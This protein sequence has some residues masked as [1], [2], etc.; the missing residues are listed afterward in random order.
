MPLHRHVTS[1]GGRPFP[2]SIP[3]GHDARF[4][5]TLV[6]SVHRTSF[7]E[8]WPTERSPC[9]LSLSMSGYSG[10]LP[11]VVLSR[12]LW[13]IVAPPL[14]GVLWHAVDRYR[15]GRRSAG[16]LR[17]RSAVV[18]Q[19]VADVA[20]VALAAVAT[21]AHVAVLRRDP[22]RTG[23]L[24][25]YAARGVR[26]GHLDAPVA[27][28]FDSLSA[29]ACTLACAV[30]LAA[31]ALVAWRPPPGGGGR[32]LAWIEL[33]LSGAL[34]SF[35]ADGLVAL[36]L[37]WAVAAASIG[38][39]AGWSDPKAGVLAATRGAF[40]LAALLLGGSLLFWG[41]GGTWRGDDYVGDSRPAFVAVRT[42][43]LDEAARLDAAETGRASLTLTSMPGAAV[44]VDE[45]P[46]PAMTTP[47]VAAPLTA[48]PHTL[49][50]RP[51]VE[52]NDIR[53]TD[54][55]G[56][57][58]VPW[59]AVPV[60]PTLS[61]REV[62][63]LSLVGDRQRETALT[64][65]LHEG[66]APAGLDL[67]SSVLALWTAAAW[68]V[69]G[70]S[71]RATAPQAAIAAAYGVTAAMLGPFLLARVSFLL[72]TA[73][74]TRV[75]F[76]S[77][78][79][80]MLV[81][82]LEHGL[83]RRRTPAPFRWTPLLAAAPGALGWM[84]LGMSGDPAGTKWASRAVVCSGLVAAGALLIVARRGSRSA[85]PVTPEPATSLALA[86]LLFERAP[87]RMGMLLMSYE[88]WVINATGRAALG[89]VGALAWA[90]ALT[91]RDVVVGPA[92]AAA[93]GVVR[94][95]RRLSPIVGGSL[96]R[97]TWAAL[98]FF[99]TAAAGLTLWLRS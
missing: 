61:F 56:Q 96:A 94:F 89:L 3:A 52:S 10:A 2:S 21:L 69:G 90:V 59:A 18:S 34:L 9:R 6:S 50:L 77:A 54:A 13:L 5:N 49:L 33:A 91:D 37:G 1:K 44:F 63:A 87:V 79:A 7:A 40:A 70:P 81:R 41:L 45:A 73:P 93:A 20:S 31:A 15:V 4:K 71:P 67:V 14:L 48:G 30:C 80:A 47:F 82:V 17:S 11:H 19:R 39:L 43:G 78:G 98:A 86:A 28:S 38:W 35:L 46:A 75:L 74:G 66:S 36:S 16:A 88:R 27:L 62:G 60:G 57:A 68:A 55:E 85:E 64:R 65:E 42:G 29:L 24:V 25:E 12:T 58:G 76:V 95:A 83:R 99:A 53:V 26:I 8:V 92:D 72:A 22:A 97:V 23:V 51:G 32:E 84:A